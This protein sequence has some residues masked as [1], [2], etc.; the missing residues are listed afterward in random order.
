ME[1]QSGAEQVLRF[2]QERTNFSPAHRACLA[3]L[4]N[5]ADSTDSVR[6]VRKSRHPETGFQMVHH[7]EKGLFLETERSRRNPHAVEN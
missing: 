3:A 7:S 5:P 4:A 6:C 1:S 2:E